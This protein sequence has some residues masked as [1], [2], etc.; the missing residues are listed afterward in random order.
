[1]TSLVAYGSDS[2]QSGEEEDFFGKPTAEGEEETKEIDEKEEK[3]RFF[4]KKFSFDQ[5]H[6]Q[7]EA[8][9][10]QDEKPLLSSFFFSGEG[11]EGSSDS[12]DDE[13]TAPKKKRRHGESVTELD[14]EFVSFIY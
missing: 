1:M 8:E 13:E 10:K 4:I 14:K 2:E 7:T 11:A 5:L 12:E 3:V 6:I 9:D